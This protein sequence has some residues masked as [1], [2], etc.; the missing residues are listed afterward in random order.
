M[1]VCVCVSVSSSP[2]KQHLSSFGCLDYIHGRVSDQT[3]D[4]SQNKSKDQAV[5]FLAV[6][7]VHTH[8]ILV[9]NDLFCQIWQEKFP[10][11][12]IRPLDLGQPLV[13]LIVP[14][15]RI[16]ACRTLLHGVQQSSARCLSVC[17]WLAC[18]FVCKNLGSASLV[19]LQSNSIYHVV[20]KYELPIYYINSS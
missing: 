12:K 20:I 15:I 8:E 6:D 17:V 18:F 3:V 5:Y 16:L 4:V 11:L 14:N 10:A 2:S 9:D 7:V 19:V 13:T 1:C